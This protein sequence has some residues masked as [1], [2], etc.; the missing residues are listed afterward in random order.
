MIIPHSTHGLAKKPRPS[1]GKLV[2]IKGTTA[3]WMA[4]SVEAVMPILSNREEVCEN[5]CCKYNLNATQ[6]H[7]NYISYFCHILT[8]K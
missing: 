2:N 6:L 4:Q 8:I 7:L 1:S 3:Q 5:P